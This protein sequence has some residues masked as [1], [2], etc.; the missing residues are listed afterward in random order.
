M[1]AGI[2]K[3]YNQPWADGRGPIAIV[4][5]YAPWFFGGFGLIYAAGLKLAEGAL[6]DGGGGTA[7][8]CDRDSRLLAATV[9]LP[10]LGYVLQSYLRHGHHGCR[11][12][13]EAREH[14][15]CA[16]S[17]PRRSN[18][19][20]GDPARRMRHAGVDAID[21][22]RPFV[23]EDYTQLYYTPI[24]RSLH[25]EHRLRYNQLFGVRINEYIMM[26]E[27]DLVE[28]LLVP[29]RRH[30]S[31]RGGCSAGALHRHHDRRGEAPLPLLRRA[32]SRLLSRA[33]RRRASAISRDL[34]WP[35]RALFASGR[36]RWPG[37]LAFAL[38]YLMAME[39]SSD[40]ARPRP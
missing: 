25:R 19:W 35:T 39:E 14:E 12:V 26:L 7:A 9:T 20:R 13:A 4:T 40:R 32:Q 38:W 15:R 21:L 36:P 5:D 8:P 27:A 10:T 23:P 1:R 24:Y 18:G 22:S 11:P 28:R 3:V 6:L 16:G 30:P 33:L 34:P 31:G 29:L 17:I 2:L 37:R